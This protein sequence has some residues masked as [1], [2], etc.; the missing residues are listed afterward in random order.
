MFLSGQSAAK[1]RIGESST[2]KDDE[3][4]PVESE[5]NNDDSKWHAPNIGDDIVYAHMK[6]WEVL[7]T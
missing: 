5:V 6:I 1:P 7:I 4:N 2:T 3:C